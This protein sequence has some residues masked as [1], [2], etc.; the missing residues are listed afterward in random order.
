MLRL[1]RCSVAVLAMTAILAGTL[2]AADGDIQ[3]LRQT[4]DQAW[5]VQGA[6]D[7]AERAAALPQHKA[8]WKASIVA[9]VAASAVDAHSSW[10]KVEANPLLANGN[11]RFGLQS[12]ALKGAITGGALGAQW[13]FLRHNG[14]NGAT[15]KGRR[16]AT[17][18]NFALAGIYARVAAHNYGNS[19]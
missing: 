10:G 4:P 7:S 16:V 3:A 15:A 1:T 14:S 18:A 19:R 2:A 8:L 17:V 11:G 12:L 9:L 6:R 13:L 5:L